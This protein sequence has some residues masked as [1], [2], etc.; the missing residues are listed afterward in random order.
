MIK[1]EQFDW[2]IP[3]VYVLPWKPI[4]NCY[5]YYVIY[6]FS[7]PNDR[8]VNDKKTIFCLLN[9]AIVRVEI[10]LSCKQFIQYNIFLLLKL[11]ICI[12]KYAVQAN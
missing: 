11:P 3:S 1:I 10:L 12:N 6:H 2:I 7:V 4:A 9:I 8:K 5:Y